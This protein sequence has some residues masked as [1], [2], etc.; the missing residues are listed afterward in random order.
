MQFFRRFVELELLL[1]GMVAV[2][3]DVVRMGGLE[4]SREGVRVLMVV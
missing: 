4:V 2:D 3:D 1:R